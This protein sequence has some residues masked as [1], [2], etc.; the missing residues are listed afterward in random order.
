[1][2]DK[3]SSYHNPTVSSLLSKTTTVDGEVYNVSILDTAGQDEYAVFKPQWSIGTHG[4][5]LVYSVTD[6]TS[7]E[8]LNTIRNHLLDCHA[9]DIPI[10]LCG[11]KSDCPETEWQVSEQ[12][13][14]ELAQKWKS[15]FVLCSAKTGANV[16]DVYE[17]LLKRVAVT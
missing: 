2:D 5:V 16:A 3:F 13:G 8:A 7:F 12:E 14:A 10:V 15:A 9:P 17:A 1:V 11:N 6:S 4:Y